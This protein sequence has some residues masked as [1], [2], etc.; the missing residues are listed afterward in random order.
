MTPSKRLG[1]LA[2]E[3]GLGTEVVSH[4]AWPIFLG[5]GLALLA[6]GVVMAA[7][8][9]VSF[10]ERGSTPGG[11]DLPFVDDY[12]T[13]V[14]VIMAPF[15]AFL[16]GGCLTFIGELLRR[17]SI[18]R[19]Y[20]NNIAIFR[21][22]GRITHA[23]WVLVPLTAW[24]VAVPYVLSQGST[25]P[26][27]NPGMSYLDS[28][29]DAIFL[30]GVYGGLAAALVGA[31]AG[32]LVKK[33]WFVNAVRRLSPIGSA[34]RSQGWWT[35]SYYWRGDVWLVSLG[36]LLLGIAPISIFLDSTTGTAVTVGGGA[37]LAATGLVTCT[38]Y[39]RAGMP[40]GTGS[41]ISG[42]AQVEAGAA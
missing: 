7:V 26:S 5:I 32:S 16:I 3:S 12:P 14:D 13:V 33:L 4:R 27:E 11:L 39:R 38:M 9:S 15:V 31:L 30:S 22:M 17:G 19:G 10:V 29:S 34:E 35:F 42:G 36:F 28:G 24:A 21:P 6:A 18:V 25:G 23:A 37:I 1:S 2:S 40:L 8:Y 41:S 20:G